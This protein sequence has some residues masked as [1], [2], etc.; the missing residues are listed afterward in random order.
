MFTDGWANQ[1][2]QTELGLTFRYQ[3][4]IAIDYQKELIGYPVEQ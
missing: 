3:A 2:H 1:I 4:G